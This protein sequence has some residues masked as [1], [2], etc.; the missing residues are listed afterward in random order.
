VRL[1]GVVA[2]QEFDLS[3]HA[4]AF[5]PPSPLWERVWT[6]VKETR[7]R[8]GV[9][10]AMGMKLS[11]TF[12]QAGLPAPRLRYEADLGSGP[13]WLGYAHWADSIRVLLP[14]IERLGT[15]TQ[16]ELDLETLADRLREETVSRGGVARLPIL[17]SA[18]VRTHE[19]A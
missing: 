14:H 15:A 1:G 9:E 13:D 11:G 6:V 18:W 10:S 4:D 2:F 19:A 7:R 17:V 16:Q 12:L 5:F 3:S 8:A